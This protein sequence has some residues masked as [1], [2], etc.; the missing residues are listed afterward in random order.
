M[1]HEHDSNLLGTLEE[2]FSRGEGLRDLVEALVQL[3]VEEEV[4]AYLGA[5]RYERSSSRTGHRAGHKPRR[6]KTRVGELRFQVP[7]VKGCEP[8]HPSMYA[9]W[10]RSERALLTACGEMYFQGVSTRKVAAVLREMCD[11]QLSASTVSRI[12]AELDERLDVFRERRLDGSCYP[13]LIIDARYEKVRRNRHVV[14]NAVLVVAGI[15]HTGNREVLDWSVGDSES[16]ETWRTI[17]RRLK[18]KG[19]SGVELIV[20]DAHG[21]IKAAMQKEFQG[22]MWQRCWVHFMREAL[23]KTSHKDYKSLSHDLRYIVNGCT[24]EECRLRIDDVADRW[25]TL[26]RSRVAA[27]VREGAHECLAIFALPATHRRRLRSTNMLERVMQELKRRSRIIGIFPNVA[28]CDRVMGT[29]LLEM[30]EAWQLE[31]CPYV[32]MELKE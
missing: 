27:H 32:N 14:N 13:Y 25:D 21:G 23:K 17:F 20:S 19:L 6:L 29:R 22:V 26:G 3:G 28:S 8:Y 4:S 1:T 16:E 30:H 10:Q 7:Q 11:F 9:H 5:G 24:E 31:K 18:A 15:T 12:A 2:M